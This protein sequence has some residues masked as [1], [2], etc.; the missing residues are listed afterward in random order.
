MAVAGTPLVHLLFTY[1]RHVDGFSSETAGTRPE[2]I[3]LDDQ[4]A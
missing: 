4:L 2:R 3:H 1:T